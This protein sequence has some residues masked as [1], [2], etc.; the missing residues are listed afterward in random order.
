MV[1]LGDCLDVLPTFAAGSFDLILTDPPYGDA[2]VSGAQ[3]EVRR[4]GASVRVREAPVFSQIVGDSALPLAWLPEAYRVLKDGGAAY[5]FC[6]WTR[7]GELASAVT[8][9]GFTVKNMI[10]MNK[11]NHGM[12]DLAGSYAPKHELLLFAAKGRH[13][14]NFPPRLKD[15]WDVPVKFS[16]AR[17]EHPNEKPAA[18]LTPAILASSKPGGSVLDPFAGSGST[19][20]AAAAAGR[21]ACGIEIDPQWHAVAASRVGPGGGGVVREVRA[22]GSPEPV[23]PGGADFGVGE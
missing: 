9:A 22:E 13:V 5:I 11:S 14:L 12:G 6:R 7:W 15:V 8:A 1:H 19:L 10:V 17:R 20:V 21:V 16:G 23:L 4:T 18:W 3:K 2:F